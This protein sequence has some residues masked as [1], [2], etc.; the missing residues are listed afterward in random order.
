ME[1]SLTSN[2][3]LLNESLEPVKRIEDDTLTKVNSNKDLL[4]KPLE[5]IIEQEKLDL[6]VSVPILDQ[7]PFA[8]LDNNTKI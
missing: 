6:V 3:E 5:S 2:K 1:S 7:D 8:I 4:N